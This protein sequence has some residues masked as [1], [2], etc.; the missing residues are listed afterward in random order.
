MF[1]VKI[2]AK[3]SS[4]SVFSFFQVFMTILAYTLI[5]PILQLQAQ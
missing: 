3:I 5:L 1:F 4:T 2:R